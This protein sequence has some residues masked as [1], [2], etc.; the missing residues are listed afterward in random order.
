MLCALLLAVAL[1]LLA[2]EHFPDGEFKGFTKGPNERAVSRRDEAFNVS[3]VHGAILAKEHHNPL[4]S[5]LLEIRGPNN[6]DQILAATADEAGQ[7]K[8]AHVP[9]GI[10]AFKATMSGYTSVVGTVIVSKRADRH[11]TIEIEMPSV[12]QAF[13]PEAVFPSVPAVLGAGGC[14]SYVGTMSVCN[15]ASAA[16][17]YV[18]GSPN[19]RRTMLHPCAIALAL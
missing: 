17:T 3:S 14:P 15:F 19:S 4:K 2:Q 7:F 12:A 11:A 6:S 1:S 5:A 10:Y 18:T 16:G 8:I 9:E 13:R